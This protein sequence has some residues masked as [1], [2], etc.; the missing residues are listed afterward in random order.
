[1]HFRLKA[2]IFDLS[3]NPTLESIYTSPTVLLDLENVAVA[4]GMLLLS[5]TQAEIYVCVYA[6]G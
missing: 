3:L 5:W 4:I 6:S 2:A 1:M